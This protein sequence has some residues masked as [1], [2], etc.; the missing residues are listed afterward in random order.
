[1]KSHLPTHPSLLLRAAEPVLRRWAVVGTAACSLGLAVC[2]AA[3]QA[4]PPTVPGKP[5]FPPHTE[6]FKGY[7]EVVSTIDRARPL[8]SLWV[9]P[10][11]NQALAAFP[12]DYAKKRFFIAL[13][14]ASGERYAGLQAGELYVYFRQHGKQMVMIA[15]NL[16][17][18]STGDPQSRASVKR[19]FTDRVVVDVPILTMLTNWGPTIDLDGLLVGHAEKFFGSMVNGAQ[20]HL[21]TLKTAKAFPHNIEVAFELPMRDGTLKTLYYSISE[22][23]PNPA[24]KPRPADE[25]VGYFTTSY[26]DLGKYQ[27]EDARVRYINRWHLEKADPNLKVSPVK[28]P[29]I[30]YIE[31]TTPIR[32]RRWVREGILMWNKAFERIG[33]ANAIEVYYQ[34]A[35]TGAHMEKDPEDVRYNFIRWLNNDVGTAIGPS[36]VNPLTGEILD[37]D[38]ILTDGW[39]RHFWRQFTQ[40]VPQL[41]TEGF[42]PETLAWL[43]TRP[44]FDPRVLLAA[45]A[46]R[47]AVMEEIRSRGPQAYGG[48]PLATADASLLG[49]EE[50]DGL[51]HRLSQVNGY[52]RAAE[53]RALDMALARF[54]LELIR[55]DQAETGG[56]GDGKENPKPEPKEDLLDG[57]PEWF[58]GPLVADLVAHEVG[59]TLGLRHNFKASSLYRLEEINSQDLKGKKPF[60]ASVMDYLPINI[61]RIHAEDP[62]G[63]YAMIGIGPYDY[64]AIEY[65]Y[66]LSDKPEDLKKIASRAAEPELQYATDEDTFGPDPLARRYDF[67]ADPVNYARRQ[68]ELAR[69]HRSRLLTDFVKEG[70]SWARAR[71]GYELTLGLQTRSLSMMA[72]WIGGMFVHRDKKGDPNGRPPLE[73]VPAAEQREA[74]QFVVENAFRDEAFGLTPE[75][76]RHLT[77][78]K[79]LDDSS[80]AMDDSNWPV[81]DR[82][83][84]IQAST[85]TMILNPTTLGRVFD[86]EMATP[87]GEDALT[88]PE[89]FATLHDAIWSELQKE[90][91]ATYTARRP[92]I[93]SLRR[94]LQ[95]EYL[96]RLIDLSM[97]EG[98]PGASHKPVATLALNQLRQLNEEIGRFL[99][100]ET[101]RLDPYTRAHLT[102]AQVRIQQALDLRYV[103]P[104]AGGA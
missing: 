38:I 98:W 96:E 15:E 94:N 21:A 77:T 97:P 8:L 1:M 51:V 66:S 16:E 3:G 79:W 53:F 55:P 58:V 92:L 93:S 6:V 29:I 19:L 52:C 11:D 76:L 84:A 88:L 4:K 34:D 28:N 9:R 63:D 36:R 37:A 7:T 50:Y 2:L 17:T 75:L 40:V 80:R 33:L 73:V 18:R 91:E 100:A 39:I 48:H 95:R 10:Q 32:Y 64:W 25:R 57:I 49:D 71:R 87:A 12:R 41:A 22:I 20:K 60:A 26:R 70:E 43:Q 89:L 83:M 59:H 30:F 42:S 44:Q 54:N 56:S 61:Y 47:L 45:P 86:N 90:P 104:T 81:H 69:Y 103:Y 102:E 68:M 101:G 72:N 23:V 67:A 78:D 74:L 5:T 85:L 35:A 62:Q 27:V 24:Y 13:T 14:V 82:I 99:A 31:H 46:T 65:G